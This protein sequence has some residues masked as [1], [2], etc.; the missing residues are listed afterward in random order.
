[1]VKNRGGIAYYCYSS[2]GSTIITNMLITIILITMI[3]IFTSIAITRI[4]ILVIIVACQGSG[5]RLALAV[6]SH[7]FFANIRHGVDTC[8]M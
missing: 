8:M 5:L 7:I 4:A 2:I 6:D 3:P 1:M